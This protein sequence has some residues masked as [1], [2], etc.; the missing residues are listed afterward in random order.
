MPTKE[1][2]FGEWYNETVDKA[3]LC[4]KRY[5]IKGMNVWT[6]LRLEDHEPDRLLPPQGDGGH[7]P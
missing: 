6:P 3:K 5:P 2:D 4:D 1:E 7:G